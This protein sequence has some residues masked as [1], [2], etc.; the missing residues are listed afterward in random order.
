M[1]VRR[2]GADLVFRRLWEETG[3]QRVLTGL[4]EE[5]RYEFDV[6]RAIYLTV[7]HRVFV[8]GSDRSSERW[9]E[10]Y[11]IEG[12]EGLELHHL[13]RAMAFLG[14]PLARHALQEDRGAMVLGS[15]RCIKD[16]VEEEL[17]E[18]RRDLFAEVDLV[19]FDTTSIYFE[20]EGGET[21]GAYGHSKD[22]RPDLKQ[23][24]VG[25][26]LDAEGRPLCCELWPGNTTDVKT[27]LLVVRRMQGRFRVREICVVADGPDQVI[28]LAEGLFAQPPALGLILAIPDMGHF[29]AQPVDAADKRLRLFH[30]VLESLVADKPD[31]PHQGAGG[32]AQQHP[33]HGVVDVGA[34]AGGVQKGAFQIQRLG[35][36]QL[37]GGLGSLDQ[38]LLD[39]GSHLRLRPPAEV[40]LE[41]TLAGHDHAVDLAQA[42]EELQ[43]GTVGQADGKA[44]VVLLDEDAG[45]I[46]TQGAP[47]MKLVV[48]LG[49]GADALL[50]GQPALEIRLDHLGFQVAL[51]QQAVDA[52][53]LVA[54]V[55]IIDIALDGGQDVGQWQFER[56]HV[57]SGHEAS[58]YS[59]LANA[60]KICKK[61]KE[62]GNHLSVENPGDSLSRSTAPALRE[63]S[64]RLGG[65]HRPG[66]GRSG[67]VGTAGSER[68]ASGPVE[69]PTAHSQTPSAQKPP[70]PTIINGG[71]PESARDQP[72]IFPSHCDPSRADIGSGPLG[73]GLLRP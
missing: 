52:Q 13:Y 27:L 11:R 17:F 45:D 49:L 40:A 71:F 57:G 18:P 28:H 24:I 6:E 44:A 15:P 54:K 72:A 12:V 63:L 9:R 16:V 48:S 35:Q 59:S 29:N 42:A 73:Q 55:A 10:R 5:R 37:L 3:I 38:E 20:G 60:S 36:P 51:N 21:L 50:S 32:I 46:A 67:P 41:G 30:A 22:H 2:I 61:G 1:R 47:G 43:E 14:E 65:G 70:R 4:L 31:R 34:Q 66:T 25:I 58:L 56:N 33:V 68:T 69:S 26:A 39:Q 8:S 23:M 19:F 7:L 62:N 64:P 53:Q